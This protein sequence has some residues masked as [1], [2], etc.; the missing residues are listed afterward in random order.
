MSDVINIGSRRELFWDEYLLDTR[1]TTAQLRLHQPQE[2]EVVMDHDP[3]VARHPLGGRLDRQEDG[4]R[5]TRPC[6][7][8][9]LAA[10][11]ALEQAREVG[12]RFVDIHG[13]HVVTMT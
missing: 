2:R 10:L 6:V 13:G 4:D 1:Q 7:P 5:P 8:D 12:L 9:P 11:D 3:V